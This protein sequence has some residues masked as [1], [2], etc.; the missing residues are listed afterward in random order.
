MSENLE[1]LTQAAPTCQ[2]YP[3]L[4]SQVSAMTLD[5]GNPGTSPSLPLPSAGNTR[6]IWGSAAVGGWALQGQGQISYCYG[7]KYGLL[8]P[9]SVAWGPLL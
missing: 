6:D 9:S 5:P 3:P 2:E 1:L 4:S 8:L 7:L